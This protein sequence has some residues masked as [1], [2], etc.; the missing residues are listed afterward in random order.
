[1]IEP[2]QNYSV[3]DFAGLSELADFHFQLLNIIGSREGF[4]YMVGP[5]RAV[6]WSESVALGS[7]HNRLYMS[8]GAVQAAR[9]AGLVFDVTSQ[10]GKDDL[11]ANRS[12]LI[13]DQRDWQL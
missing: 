4:K 7:K 2:I 1:M 8:D 12:L 11:P 9:A 3:V 13:G 10:I 5:P 6:I